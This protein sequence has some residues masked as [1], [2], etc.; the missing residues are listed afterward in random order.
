ML[1]FA[2]T[3]V[4]RFP[5]DEPEVD[6]LD[7]FVWCRLM[8]TGQVVESDSRPHFKRLVEIQL[9]KDRSD[10]ILEAFADEILALVLLR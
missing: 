3:K 7:L 10:H 6:F 1:H 2:V 4:R 9:E 5:L 8:K